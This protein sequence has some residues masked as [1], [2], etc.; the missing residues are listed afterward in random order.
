MPAILTHKAV[1]LLA[2]ERL[3]ELRDRLDAKLGA[4]GTLTDL[5]Y[6]VHFLADQAHQLLSRA[7]PVEDDTAFPT[8]QGGK[9]L[10]QGVSRFA[11]MGSMGPDITGFSGVLATP[12][13]KWV[14]D[15]IHKGTPDENREP[16]VARSTDFVLEMWRQA[17]TR[18]AART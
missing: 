10:G 17:G 13:G 5:D 9:K 7:G 16:V 1:L 14:F 8:M 11:V 6:R 12:A 15:L 18:L 4:G 2:R 3:A